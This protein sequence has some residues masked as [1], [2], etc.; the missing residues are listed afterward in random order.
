MPQLSNGKPIA[1]IPNYVWDE[2]QESVPMSTYLVA[3]VVSDFSNITDGNKF[4]VWTRD[5]AIGQ[6]K[7]SLEIGP[8]I[9]NYF[10]KYFGIDFP[11]PKVDMVALPDFA[12]GAME[13]WGLITFRET[14]LLYEA[15]VS[16]SNNKQRVATV[17]SHEL[18]HQWFGNLVT[19]SWW[20]DLWLNEG[21]ASY[22]EYLGVEAVEPSWKIMEQFVIH[23][24]QNVFALDALRTSHQISVKVH[25]P[26]EI[27][28]IFDRISYGKGASLIRMMN[29]FLTNDVFKR[30][31]SKYLKRHK[32][33][34]TEQDD[35]WAALTEQ[36]HEDMVMSKNMS[37]KT[38]MDTWTLQ[39]GFP[40]INV[41][42]DYNN[43]KAVL[44]QE[45]FLLFK[46]TGSKSKGKR[47]EKVL[48][49]VP[50]TYTTSQQLNFNKTY[51]SHWFKREEQI[52]IENLPSEKDWILLNIQQTGFYR[53][54][55]DD[56]NWKMLIDY[57]MNPALFGN[58]SPINRAQLLDDALN[59]A[60]AE[61]LS[62]DVAMNVTAYLS[63]EV[64][65][66]PW[67]SAFTAFSY[68]DNMLIKTGGYDKF[69]KYILKLIEKLYNEVGFEA[70]PNDPQLT[71]YKRIHVLLWAC[72]LG[73]GNCV[74]NSVALFKKWKE[75]QDPDKSNPISPDLKSIV[76]CTALKVGSE[77]DWN[78]AWERFKKAN[79]A[80]ERDLLLEALGCTR[81]VAILS[82]ALDWAL[83][84]NSGIR[85]QDVA[86]LF[87]SVSSN[88]FGQ[89]L[90]FNLLTE[91]W[92]RLKTYLGGSLF[93]ISSIVKSS[94]KTINTKLQ[95][96]Q[97]NEFAKEHKNEFGPATRAVS[98]A[99]EQ[100]DA[101]IRWMEQNYESLIKWLDNSIR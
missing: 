29:H 61:L 52:S 54:N 73:H 77:E 89:I 55:Y 39:T 17:V 27:S 66:L 100:A 95:L 19:P 16:S 40:V 6:A 72:S 22:V 26:D 15:G 18:A 60:R 51:P 93:T 101:N 64:E 83:T 24:V 48:W 5:S 53:V 96:K 85:K 86:R 87:G 88:P 44:N 20:S 99:L 92:Q 43:G 68:M 74:K 70:R 13:N 11:L 46:S 36:A 71:I 2:Y 45:I 14:A 65:Y 8:K 30:G 79:V 97:L 82:R 63:N 28:E 81:D 98:Q 56:R 10:E 1:G 3:F 41:K 33:S 67:R 90:V 31:L 62:Y 76:Y 7:Y 59:L 49:W 91:D 84:D 57:L 50:I 25:H 75:T 23:E 42:R 78:F 35:L 80:S 37:V 47:S 4:T 58:I 12:A 32:F 69:K 38:I 9:L 21:F 34:S 94:T